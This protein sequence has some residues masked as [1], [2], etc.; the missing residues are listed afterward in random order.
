MKRLYLAVIVI[1]ALVSSSVIMHYWS[2][3]KSNQ[4]DT[5]WTVKAA[6]LVQ[7]YQLTLMA[8]NILAQGS[9]YLTVICTWLKTEQNS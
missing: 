4:I 5:L 9:P 1:L 2:D 8:L 7:N 6:E 3:T